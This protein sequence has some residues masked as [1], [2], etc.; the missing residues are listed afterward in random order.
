[1]K[2]LNVDLKIKF[3]L[4]KPNGTPRKILNTGIAK[5]YGWKPK[6]NLEKGFNLTYTSYLKEIENNNL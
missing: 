5:N 2:K 3:E 4:D 1:M 6:F